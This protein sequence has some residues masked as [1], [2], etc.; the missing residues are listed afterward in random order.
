MHLE[1]GPEIYQKKIFRT[2]SFPPTEEVLINEWNEIYLYLSL[3][4]AT[5]MHFCTLTGY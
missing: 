3:M 1:R 5:E 4:S 2:C